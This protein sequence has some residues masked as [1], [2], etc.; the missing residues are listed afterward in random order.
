MCNEA[1]GNAFNI[2][3][4]HKHI[5]GT[6]IRRR[7]LRWLSSGLLR[8]VEVNRRFRRTYCFLPDDG[9]SKHLRNVGKFISDY[10]RY[11]PEDSYLHGVGT[12]SVA[13]PSPDVR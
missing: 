11:N 5:I 8:R 12:C 1:V 2:N 4:T 10:T 3:K 13:N 7:V 9:D 6:Q